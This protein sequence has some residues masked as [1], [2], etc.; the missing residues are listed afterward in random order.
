VELNSFQ[1]LKNC[2]EQNLFRVQ[3]CRFLQVFCQ[4]KQ[5]ASIVLSRLQ[6]CLSVDRIILYLYAEILTLFDQEI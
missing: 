1:V 2:R 4:I 5:N 6:L 3:F